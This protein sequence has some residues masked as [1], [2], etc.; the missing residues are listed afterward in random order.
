MVS[1][2]S[3]YTMVTEVPMIL[4]L[5]ELN[6]GNEVAEFVR[7]HLIDELKA[8]STFKSGDYE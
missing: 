8:L 6:V 7:D 2:F 4:T 1:A 5:N 3:E